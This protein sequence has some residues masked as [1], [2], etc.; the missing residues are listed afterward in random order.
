M[1]ILKNW[2]PGE[3]SPKGDPESM[4]E[5]AKNLEQALQEYL[6]EVTNIINGAFRLEDNADVA[7]KTATTDA[8]PGDEVAV[9]HGLK[10]TPN[11][12]AVLSTDKAA[13]IYDGSTA[14]DATN[15][16]IRSDT[17]TVAVKLLIF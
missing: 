10:R 14:N 4:A 16:Y 15:L 12:F 6:D 3:K 7:I 8:V 17:G 11:G 9:A 2:M 13:V 5:W 1:T